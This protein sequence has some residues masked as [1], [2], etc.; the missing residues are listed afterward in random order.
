MLRHF[1]VTRLRRLRR[2]DFLRRLVRETR[3][4]CDDLIYPIFIIEGS[5]ERQAINAMPGIERLSID[6]LLEEAAEVQ[7]LGI[8]AIA[9]FPSIN[10]AVKSNNPVEAYNPEG[11]VPMAIRA[12]KQAFPQLGIIA[13]VALDPYTSHGQD[14]IIDNDGYV[15]NDETIE[16]LVKQSLCLAAAGVD[17]IAP[18][19]MMDGRVG[20]IRNALEKNGY[21]NTCILAYSA[22]YA[23]KY[24]GPFREAVGSAV[25]LGKGDKASYQMDFANSN[26]ALQE[27]A[28]DLAEGADMVMIKPGMPYLDIVWR[29]KEQFQV[30]TLVYQVSGEYAMH[31]AAI[32]NGWL[33]EEAIMESVLAIKRAGADAILTY[34]AKR[35]AR[36]LRG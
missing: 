10:P 22:K 25:Q 14:G 12:L 16:F 26:E 17:I 5:N 29:V 33:S 4:S 30:P 20:A 9:L 8:P 23:S 6:R 13:D 28:L 15:L 18:S 1:P 32:K 19:D 21:P 7:A 35:I 36:L 11:L 2:T 3:L 31:M 34:F 24:Y 27:V